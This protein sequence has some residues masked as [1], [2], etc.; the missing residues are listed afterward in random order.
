[1]DLSSLMNVF[2]SQQSQQGISTATGSSSSD[3]TSILASALPSLLAGA[4]KQ[5][6]Q[7]ST[8]T[9]FAKAL[10]SHAQDDTSNLSSF[11]NNVDLNDG[12]KI[13]Q[14]LLGNKTNATIK[15]VANQ[16]GVT[17]SQAGN[18]LAAAA[19]LLLSLLGQQ[20]TAQTKTAA[21]Q[22]AKTAQTT[23]LMSSLLSNVD[24]GSLIGTMLGSGSSSK[25]SSSKKSGVDLSDGLD[26]GDVV[27]IMGKL[28]K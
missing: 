18:V 24:V 17:Q 23:N 16:A 22:K 27:G 11:Y 8:A 26:I 28:I 13:I 10:A 21:T 12:A 9:S 6:Q 15:T 1:M 20:T 3:V 14:H 19:P 5:S 7:T 2:L 4:N 25:K